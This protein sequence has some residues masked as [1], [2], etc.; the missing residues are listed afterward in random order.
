[1]K[2]LLCAL[3][4]STLTLLGADVTGKWSGTFEMT[5][6]GEAHSG[7]A[8]MI[9]K[10]EGNKITGTVGASA[11]QQFPI[12]MGT[13]EENRVHLEIVPDQGPALVK[14]DLKLEAEDHML[15]DLTAEG[16]DGGFKGKIDL[17][18]EK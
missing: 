1:M 12:K 3:A 9:L 10:Q 16:G 15:G 14:L 13:I 11:D 17:K 18:R 4:L 2:T 8:Y 6:E 5:R 7:G